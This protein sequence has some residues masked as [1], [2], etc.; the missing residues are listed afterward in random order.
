[1]PGPAFDERIYIVTYDIGEPRRWRR[2]FKL[3]HGYGEWLQLSVFQCR[4][5]R[6]RRAELAAAI[7]E[8]INHNQDHVLILD[9]GSVERVELR[10]ESMGKTYAPVSREPIIV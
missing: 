6:R 3:M 10:V 7:N 8:V 4:L 5:T 1:M 9:L 2:L